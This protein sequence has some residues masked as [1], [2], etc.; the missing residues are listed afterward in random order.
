MESKEQIINIIDNNVNQIEQLLSQKISIWKEYV[1]FSKLW[2]M[3]VALSIIPWV[4]W[5][6]YRRKQSTDRLLYVGFLVMTISL[7]LDVLGDQLGLW[8]YRFQVIPV[9]PT[10][11]PWD[12]TF[13]PLGIMTL[14]QVK[15]DTNPWLKAILFALF[16]SYLAEPFFQ[17]LSVYQPSHWRYSYS[18][19]IQFTIYMAANYISRRNKFSSL[20]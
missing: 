4:L 15:P 18:V 17:W 11:I 13:M 10:Y 14:I 8:H 2:W 12:I 20:N 16:T 9:L 19:P 7:G 5:S 6:I 1:L 3:G